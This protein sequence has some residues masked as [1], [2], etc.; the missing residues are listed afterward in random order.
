MNVDLACKTSQRHCHLS[1]IIIGSDGEAAVAAAAD[2]HLV[3]ASP[4]YMDAIPQAGL[5]H[6]NVAV[7]RI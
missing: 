5:A 6:R 4:V 3:I 1:S 7:S 2:V